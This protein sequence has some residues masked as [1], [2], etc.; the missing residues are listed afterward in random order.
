M[1]LRVH[2]GKEGQSRDTCMPRPSVNNAAHS[3]F[4]TQRRHH[5]KS[6]TGVSVSSQKGLMSSKFYF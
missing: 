6:E 4:E 1:T 3:G 5:Q 2:K